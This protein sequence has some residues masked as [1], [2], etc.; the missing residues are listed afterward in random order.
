MTGM[1]AHAVQMLTDTDLL[2]KEL[3]REPSP[4]EVDKFYSQSKCHLVA[5]WVTMVKS[6]GLMYIMHS[7]PAVRN[8]VSGP[9]ARS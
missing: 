8:F 4:V 3:L 5:L 6:P 9:S 7:Y 1:K 2:I